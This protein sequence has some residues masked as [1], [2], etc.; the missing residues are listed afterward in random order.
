MLPNLVNLLQQ[1]L[2][3]STAGLT[4][5]MSEHLQQVT[6]QLW[7]DYFH[8]KRA[9]PHAKMSFCTAE[10]LLKQNRAHATLL[11]ACNLH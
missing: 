1:S 7:R 3:S 5:L 11:N 9:Q 2:Q 8:P 10:S 6:K 4:A